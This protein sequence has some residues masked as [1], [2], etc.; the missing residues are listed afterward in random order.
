MMPLM[1]HMYCICIVIVRDQKQHFTFTFTKGKQ[2]HGTQLSPNENYKCLTP[3]NFSSFYSIH[4][5]ML[6]WV[7]SHY[8]NEGEKYNVDTFSWI[9][10]ARNVNHEI[11]FY[12]LTTYERKHRA[13]VIDSWNNN[14]NVSTSSWATYC[15][16]LLFTNT[17][18]FS[19]LL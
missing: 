15:A 12:L 16:L 11:T 1:S 5:E 17:L 9:V 14:C 2:C 4:L 7:W 13:K 6:Y 3:C 10:L 18:S 8:A 19:T